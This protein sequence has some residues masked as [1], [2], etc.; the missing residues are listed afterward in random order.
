MS[1]GQDRI[2]DVLVMEADRETR[3]QL[4]VDACTPLDGQ[5]PVP[6][7]VDMLSTTPF[8]LLRAVRARLSGANEL[9]ATELERLRELA[10]DVRR[11]W[12]ASW[13]GRAPPP[14]I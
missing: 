2:L 12:A 9:S 1:R 13:D 6:D 7:D 14:S 3:Q 8:I 11:V 5:A 4:V 10:V